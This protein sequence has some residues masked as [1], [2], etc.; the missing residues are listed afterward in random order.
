M[1]KGSPPTSVACFTPEPKIRQPVNRLSEAQPGSSL[2]RSYALYCLM[3]RI[4][5]AVEAHRARRVGPVLKTH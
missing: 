4:G 2:E 3:D 1:K 5:Q